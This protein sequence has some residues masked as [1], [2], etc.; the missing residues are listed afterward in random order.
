VGGAANRHGTG[1]FAGDAK[2]EIGGLWWDALLWT[3][4]LT[5][6][7]LLLAPV[8]RL[9]AMVASAPP[10]QARAAETETSFTP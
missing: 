9:A 8:A 4:R 5:V 3:R 1:R 2:D 10:A 7:R 6:V